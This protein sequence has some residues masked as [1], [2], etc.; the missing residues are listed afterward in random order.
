MRAEHRMDD[1]RVRREKLLRSRRE[2]CVQRLRDTEER[3][4]EFMIRFNPRSESMVR[5]RHAFED[6]LRCFAYAVA[7]IETVIEDHSHEPSSSR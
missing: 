2:L 6:A 1:W 3:Y 7:H 4:R 5:E